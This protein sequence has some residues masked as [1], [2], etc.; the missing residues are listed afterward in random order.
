MGTTDT[1]IKI[2]RDKHL[3]A[4]KESERAREGKESHTDD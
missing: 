3:D 2:D 1:R 4:N